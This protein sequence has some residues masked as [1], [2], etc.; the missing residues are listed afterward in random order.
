MSQKRALLLVR[1][2]PPESKVKEFNDWYNNTHVAA[3]LTTPGFL[4]ARRFTKI[5][6]IL[7]APLI[8]SDTEYLA[9]YD[10][11]ST[12]VLKDKPYQELRKREAALPPDSFE[13]LIHE[14]PKFAR[15]TYVQIFPDN[16]EY[17]IPQTR[18]VFVV[19]HDVP[20]NRHEEFNAWY[21][22]EHI[23]ALLSVPG[24]LSVR[25][26]KLADEA[27]VSR[28]GSVSQYF[29]IWDIED[30][31]ALTSDAFLKAANSPWSDWVRSWY[32]RKIRSL[33]RC[34]FPE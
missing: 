33:Y 22:A 14:M 18:V 19:G 34:I 26:F 9:L 24:F 20:Q 15:G 17:V 30:E 8:T 16:E 13:T 27:I 2:D 32:T 21:N 23:P 4:S 29:T 7:T 31:S 3:R 5:D 1:M 6:G 28:G 12:S 25:R 11:T 10:L